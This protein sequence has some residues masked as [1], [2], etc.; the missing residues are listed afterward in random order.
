[1][2]TAGGRVQD[3]NLLLPLVITVTYCE[4]TIVRGTRPGVFRY[5]DSAKAQN[6]EKK[7]TIAPENT[8]QYYYK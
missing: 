3:L 1:V 8:V 5:I 7:G 4:T 6:M 2:T